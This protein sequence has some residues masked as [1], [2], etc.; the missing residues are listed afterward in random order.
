VA[1]FVAQ[2]NPL[3]ILTAEDIL[4]FSTLS[5]KATKGA[6]TISV[7]TPANQIIRQLDQTEQPLSVLQNNKAIGQ[8]DKSALLAC[9][10]HFTD[11]RQ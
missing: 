4:S 3:S 9:L 7:T 2:I 6:Q 10:A 11:D 5:A 8:I 1:N